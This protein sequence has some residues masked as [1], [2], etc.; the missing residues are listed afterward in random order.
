MLVVSIVQDKCRPDECENGVCTA[1]ASCAWKALEQSRPF[2]R[3]TINSNTCLG[4]FHCTLFCRHEALIV[5]PS[6]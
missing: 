1:V 2:T 5:S 6:R 3:P 4:C